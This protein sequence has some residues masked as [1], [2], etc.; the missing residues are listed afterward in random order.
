[1]P[2][3]P[4][5]KGKTTKLAYKLTHRVAPTAAKYTVLK[6]TQPLINRGYT[7]KII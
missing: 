3:M 7:M 1:M 5:P 2:A 4:R 6:L